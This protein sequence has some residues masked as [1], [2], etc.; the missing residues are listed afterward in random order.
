MFSKLISLRDKWIYS[1][2]HGNIY[3]YMQHYVVLKL[4]R[5]K[6]FP[7][8]KKNA[9]YIIS[10]NAVWVKIFTLFSTILSLKGF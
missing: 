2:V 6:M 7:R 4:I 8:E 1:W 10:N 9:L 5:R 3:I